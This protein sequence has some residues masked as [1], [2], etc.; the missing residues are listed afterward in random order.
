[1]LLKCRDAECQISK[2]RVVEFANIL[3][4]SRKQ[5]LTIQILLGTN[6]DGEFHI[7]LKPS[8]IFIFTRD[9]HYIFR[10]SICQS[11]GDHLDFHTVNQ[12]KQIYGIENATSQE[13]IPVGTRAC[14][15]RKVQNQEGC[16]TPHVPQ[17]GQLGRLASN[18]NSTSLDNITV[19][20]Q[21]KYE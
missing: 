7:Q 16:E 6:I 14:C 5:K 18:N 15:V 3:V 13:I 2:M 9:D 10:S 12:H 11:Q 17:C 8:P 21:R 4:N 20:A 19:T 1:M